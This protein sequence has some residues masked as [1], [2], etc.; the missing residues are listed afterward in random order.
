MAMLTS[1]SAHACASLCT[2]GPP[3]STL[4]AHMRSQSS[5]QPAAQVAA[6][7]AHA[8]LGYSETK[9]SGNTTSDAPSSAASPILAMTVSI[10]ASASRIAG[11]AW[12]AATRI[13]SNVATGRA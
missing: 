3:T 13:V 8:P 4:D 11:V 10:V 9:H 5:S 7:A 6:G 2:N 12:T 1:R